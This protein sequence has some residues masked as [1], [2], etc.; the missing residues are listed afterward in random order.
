MSS[1]ALPEAACQLD[2][3][4]WKITNAN[5]NVEE[6]RGPGVVGEYPVMMPGKV[7]EYASCTTFSTTSEYMEGHYTFHRLANKE[8]V[9][10]VLIPR[11]HMVCPPFRKSVV[12]SQG[13]TNDR[14]WLND[15]DSDG[16]GDHGD[17]RGINLGGGGAQC[18]RHV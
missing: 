5:G 1:S 17:F 10:N 8:E 7:H 16:D 13:S 4:Y 6:V 14:S 15:D 2:S 12:R 11:F 18:P 9:F 3:R